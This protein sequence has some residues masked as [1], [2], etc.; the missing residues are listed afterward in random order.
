MARV[1]ASFAMEQVNNDGTGQEY[2]EQ[3][4]GSAVAGKK[5]YC[6]VCKKDVVMGHT[7][8]RCETC[9]GKGYL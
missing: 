7:H 2:H 4:M 5:K 6:D 3:Y 1:C 8:R 9:K